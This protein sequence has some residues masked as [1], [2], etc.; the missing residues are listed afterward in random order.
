LGTA[1]DGRV[2]RRAGPIGNIFFGD[3]THGDGDRDVSDALRLVDPTCAIQAR[4]LFSIELGHVG[5]GSLLQAR[6]GI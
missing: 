2:F 5:G 1:R 3:L 4:D 6:L